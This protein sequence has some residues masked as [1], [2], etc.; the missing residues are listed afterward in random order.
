MSQGLGRLAAVLGVTEERL[1]PFKTYDDGEL[2]RLEE[3]VRGALSAEDAAF[4]AGLTGA[5]DL[6][7]RPLRGTAR[8]ILFPGGGK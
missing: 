2:D 7:P 3:L 6:V 4:D 8:K 5:L 1:A